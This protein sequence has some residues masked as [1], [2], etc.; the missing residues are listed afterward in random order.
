MDAGAPLLIIDRV[1]MDSARVSAEVRICDRSER[2]ELGLSLPGLLA[3]EHMPAALEHH[4]PARNAVV[5]RMVRAHRG[6]AVPL[7]VD[8]SDVVRQASEPW[9]L[10]APAPQELSALKVAAASSPVAV[11]Q[12]ERDAQSGLTTVHIQVAGA[13]AVVIVDLRD[14]PQHAARFRFAEG[15][16]SWQL[17]AAAAHAMLAAL[18]TAAHPT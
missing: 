4:A 13:P 3:F 9:P 17:A 7:P 15:V 6:A 2:V 10:P 18:L 12:I 16:H 1:E 11:T 5:D 14:G 8:L